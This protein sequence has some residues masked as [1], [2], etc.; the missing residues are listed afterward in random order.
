M[1]QQLAQVPRPYQRRLLRQ[2]ASNTCFRHEAETAIPLIWPDGQVPIAGGHPGRSEDVADV[3]RQSL[4]A[5]AA[6]LPHP[7]FGGT[8]LKIVAFQVDRNRAGRG[9]L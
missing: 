4:L 5:T 7:I 9:T 8:K 1:V 3:V 6:S 2:M